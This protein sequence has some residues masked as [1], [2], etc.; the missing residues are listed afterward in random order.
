MHSKGKKT[1]AI[2]KCLAS[3][4]YIDS[5]YRDNLLQNVVTVDTFSD[6][7]NNKKRGLFCDDLTNEQKNIIS[8]LLCNL[9]NIGLFVCPVGELE[10]WVNMGKVRMLHQKLSSLN[11]NLVATQH[12]K[13]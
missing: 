5:D 1:S 6:D 11:I 13:D 2:R 3:L 4:N 9:G 8:T 12:I 7:L 10:N